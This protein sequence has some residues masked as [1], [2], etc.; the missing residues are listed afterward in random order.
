MKIIK[1]LLVDD[2]II[3]LD[4][5]K[6]ILETDTQ[7]NVVATAATGE[8]AIKA[9]EKCAPDVVLMDIRM[10]GMNGVECTRRIKER[11]LHIA[12]LMLTTFNDEEFILDALKYGACGYLLKDISGERL[13]QAVKDANN[14]DTI[15]PSKIAAKIAGRITQT[16]DCKEEVLKKKLGLTDR[17]A[18]LAI[19]LSQG[20]TNRQ[21]AAALFISEGT[22]KNYIS[23]I[24]RKLEI[25]DRTMAAIKIREILG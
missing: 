6:A 18:D 14:G 3:L 8:D 10:P 1:V 25:E 24:Y 15:L 16:P 2:Q 22:A 4:G 19:M 23:S 5:I 21:I 9:I 17:E 11:W 13:L 7:I 20:F 12:V